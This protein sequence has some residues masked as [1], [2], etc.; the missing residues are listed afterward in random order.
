LA[1]RDQRNRPGYRPGPPSFGPVSAPAGA[2]SPWVQLRSA[3]GNPLIFKRMVRA[4]D[5]AA[6]PG[7]VVNIYDKAGGLFGRGLYNPR[8]M[9]ALR[10]LTHRDVAIDDAFWRAALSR[11]VELRRQLRIHE[12]SD[13]YRLVHAEGDG[14]SGLIVEKYADVL[15]FEVFSLGMYQRARMLAEIIGNQATRQGGNRGHEVPNRL[16]VRADDFIERTEGFRVDPA[17]QPDVGRLII[18]EHGVR[19]R[20]DVAGGHKTGFFCDQRDNR[21]QFAGLCRDAS[22]LD[23][24]CYTG[25]FSVCA[26]VLGG[27]REVI[28]VDLDEDAIAMAKENANLNQARIDFVHSD[29]FIYLR[30]MIAN[31][32]KFDAVVLDPPKF[33]ADREEIEEALIKYHDLN[34]LAMQVVRAGGVFVTCSCSGLVS[35]EVFKA[36]VIR[37]ARRAKVMLQF[38]A[39]TGA[40]PDH[41]VMMNCPESEYLKVIWARVT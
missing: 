12:V 7:D 40:G 26:K 30:Q 1:Q 29:A 23:L 18:R 9:I 20:I 8:S 6:R 3:S 4:A 17:L 35:R 28:G 5:P 34:A 11:A 25:G 19:Y 32:R 31:G 16:V 22:V 27:A 14:M 38:F 39:E 24:C 21:K 37:A 2:V 13:A 33:A 41:P 36:T 15:V 10:V